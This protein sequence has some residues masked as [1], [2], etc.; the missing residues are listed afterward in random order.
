MVTNRNEKP[1]MSLI[2]REWIEDYWPPRIQAKNRIL[3]RKCVC[4][5]YVSKIKVPIPIVISTK[6]QN[7]IEWK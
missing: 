7:C 6:H 1:L 3:V 2:P 4:V 5:L